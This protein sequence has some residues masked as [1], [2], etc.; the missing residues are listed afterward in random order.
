MRRIK[1]ASGTGRKSDRSKG[2]RKR[3]APRWVRNAV[4]AGATVAVFALAFGGP[5]WLWQS[6]WVASAAGNVFRGISE[7][8]AD[9][10][11]RVDEIY[12]EGRTHESADRIA[13][14]LGIGRGDPLLSVDID[15]ARERL[16]ALGWIRSAS[17]AREYPDAIRVRIVERRPLALWQRSNELVLVDDE[18]VVVTATDLHRFRNLLVIV[19]DDAPSHAGDLLAVLALAPDL[20]DRVNAAVRV[21]DRRWNIRMDNGVFVRLPENDAIDAWA[22]FARL[23]RSHGLLAQDLLSIDLR[24]PDQLIVRTRAD[25]NPVR[26][27]AADRKGKNT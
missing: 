11:L 2:T 15:G 21:G 26:Q 8:F 24:I 20:K 7:M 16:E 12:L 5:A 27:K 25:E 14:V 9:A 1:G 3:P 19:G 18:G 4:R 6:G 23:E 10:G 13:K 17:V 22:R